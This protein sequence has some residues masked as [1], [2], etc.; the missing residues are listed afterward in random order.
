MLQKTKGIV[1]R[2]IKYGDTSLITTIFTEQYGIQAYMVQGVRTAKSRNNK[3]G[4]LQPATLLEL[5]VYHKQQQSL[6]RIREFQA[7]YLYTSVHEEVVKNSIALFSVDLL[8]RLL[9]ESAPLPELFQFTNDY[10]IH[11]DKM[12]LEEVANFPV[13]FIIHCSKVL[14]YSINGEYSNDTPYLNLKEGAF[15]S[16]PPLISTVIH[17]EDAKCLSELLQVND[18]TQL[19]S[20]E[21]NAAMRYRLLDWYIEY[22]HQHTQHLGV[23][24]SLAILQAILH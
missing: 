22:L 23:I 19:K 18:L 10:F 3:A 4:L 12:S 16:H 24:K 2:S 13:F 9:P 17:D 14:G 21:M 15:T 5:I 7:S 1:L 6:Q 11:L 20:I 8:L